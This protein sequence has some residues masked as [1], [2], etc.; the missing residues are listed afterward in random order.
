MVRKLQSYN[1]GYYIPLDTYS[2]IAY[3]F[4]DY[5]ISYFPFV[6]GNNI[7]L[8]Y[9]NSLENDKY[10]NPTPLN[11]G[12]TCMRLA[13]LLPDGKVDYKM[14]MKCDARKS[15][16]KNLLLVDDNGTVYISTNGKQGYGVESFDVKE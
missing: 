5:M 14:I 16:L 4:P 15:F 12:K 1:T 7:Y 6:K 13:K 11:Y 8:V 9:N 10:C 3:S 2:K